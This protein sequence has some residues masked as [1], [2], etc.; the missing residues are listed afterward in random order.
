MDSL[1]C[2][3]DQWQASTSSLNTMLTIGLGWIKLPWVDLS[4]V[5]VGLTGLR[6]DM[7][8]L[9]KD[10]MCVHL[11]NVKEVFNYL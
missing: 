2:F 10:Y 5:R 11:F 8:G 6:W 9:R 7:E 4:C 3:L 1:S